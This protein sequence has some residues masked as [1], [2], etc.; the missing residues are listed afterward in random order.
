SN[1]RETNPLIPVAIIGR[2]VVWMSLADPIWASGQASRVKG[3]THDRIRTNAS[4]LKT[5][6]NPTGRPHMGHRVRLIPPQ[7]VKPFVKRAKNDRNDAEAISEAASRPTM[8]SVVVKTVDQ[9]ADGINH[10]QTS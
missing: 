9:Q 7:Y 10:P 2:P 4:I 5:Y 6:L 1:R 3:R 8:R